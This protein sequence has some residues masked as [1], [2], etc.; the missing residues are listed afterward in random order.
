MTDAK[1]YIF[2]LDGTLAL[3]QHFHYEAYAI[4]LKEEGIPYTREEDIA[5]YAGQG[6]EKIFPMIFEKNGRFLTAE[7]TD[8]FIKRKREVYQKLIESE[9]IQAVPGVHEY[10]EELR[11]LGKKMIVAT[12]NRRG[13]TEI[14]LK[15]TGL[16]HFFSK[17]VTVEDVQEPKPAPETFLLAARELQ[18]EP[19]ECIIFEDTIN[20]IRAAKASGITCVA[21]S[22]GTE[23]EKL[24]EA[25]A[26]KV[27]Q[28]FRELLDKK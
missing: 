11:T 24:K 26:D 16:E 21:V 25:G 4:I 8:Y 7:E 19:N 28:D 2:D 23:A 1:G 18:L 22:T 6:S 10:L 20:G 15:K 17:A 9:P 27:I 14:I 12:G 3:S 5:F 13:P